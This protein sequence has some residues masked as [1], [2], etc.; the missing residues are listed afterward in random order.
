M[1]IYDLKLQSASNRSRGLSARTSSQRRSIA[2]AL[3]CSAL[4]VAFARYAL[5]AQAGRRARKCT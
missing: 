1:S 2:S 3:S 5:S 4:R